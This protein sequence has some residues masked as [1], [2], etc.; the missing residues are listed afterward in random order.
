LRILLLTNSPRLQYLRSRRWAGWECPKKEKREKK[1]KHVAG[2]KKKKG[3]RR[4]ARDPEPRLWKKMK[5]TKREKG[6]VTG[7]LGKITRKGRLLKDNYR[8]QIRNEL[9]GN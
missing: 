8:S 7:R 9:P 3:V 2:V 6:T 1:W 4:E 5:N